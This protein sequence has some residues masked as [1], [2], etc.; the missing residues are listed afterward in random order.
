MDNRGAFKIGCLVWAAVVF[1]VVLWGWKLLDFHVLGPAAVKK[2]MNETWSQV[3][4]L[5]TTPARQAEYLT[6]WN[7]WK[8]EQNIPFQFSGFRGDTFVVLWSDTLPVPVFPDITRDF[9]LARIVR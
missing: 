9:R 7:Q 2:V 4:A 6:L 3:D 1:L 5:N 8:R